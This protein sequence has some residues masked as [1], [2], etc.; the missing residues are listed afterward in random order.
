MRLHKYEVFSF[1]T[2]NQ[3]QLRNTSAMDE[4]LQWIWLARFAFLWEYSSCLKQTFVG[5][6]NRICKWSYIFLCEK[7]AFGTI[8]LS[9]KK[10]KNKS[11]D[12]IS[13][14]T[15]KKKLQINLFILS[16]SGGSGLYQPWIKKVSSIIGQW[17]WLPISVPSAYGTTFYNIN[18]WKQLW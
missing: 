14:L 4:F 9:I 11:K 18:L 16:S 3:K 13:V 17:T 15:H 1:F 2:A 6:N 10:A 12:R 8:I 7:R 5:I